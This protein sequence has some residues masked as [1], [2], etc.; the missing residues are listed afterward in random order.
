MDL[1]APFFDELIRLASR[2]GNKKRPAR[3]RAKRVTSAAA[4]FDSLSAAAGF[5]ALGVRKIF[6]LKFLSGVR[7]LGMLRLS[8]FSSKLRVAFYGGRSR[9][10]EL[11]TKRRVRS[12]RGRVMSTAGEAL[13]SG[14]AENFIRVV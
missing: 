11:K 3:A 5:F 6:R 13:K 14:G 10:R 12:S 2:R 8:F 7:E 9:E 4:A 1:K